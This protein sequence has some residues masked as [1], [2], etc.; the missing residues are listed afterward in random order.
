[1]AIPSYA[2]FQP[3]DNLQLPESAEPRTVIPHLDLPQIKPKPATSLLRRLGDVGVTL[4][5]SGISVPEQFIG[6]ADIP[7]SGRVG[8]F[9]EEQLNFKPKEVKA[10]LDTMY[11]PA[12]QEANQA[13]HNTEG[14]IPSLKSYAEYPSVAAHDILGQILPMASSSVIGKAA[15]IVNPKLSQLQKGVL[16]EVG[17]I[18]GQNVE[19]TRQETPGGI[20]DPVKQTLPLVG[21]AVLSGGIAGASGRLARKM[22]WTDVQNIIGGGRTIPGTGSALRN[23][24]GAMLSEGLLQEAPQSWQEQV[25]QNYALDKPLLE[26]TGSAAAQGAVAGAGLGG[27]A[28]MLDPATYKKQPPPP[29]VETLPVERPITGPITQAAAAGGVNNGSRTNETVASNEAAERST[30]SQGDGQPERGNIVA[31]TVSGSGVRGGRSGVLPVETSLGNNRVNNPD[32]AAKRNKLINDRITEL[33]SVLQDPEIDDNLRNVTERALNQYAA[34]LP[35][36]NEP[37]EDIRAQPEEQRTGTLAPG[38]NPVNM[39][40]EEGNVTNETE[41]PIWTPQEPP[42]ATTVPTLENVAQEKPASE[43]TQ[44]QPKEK[45]DLTKINPNQATTRLNDDGSYSVVHAKT[46]DDLI[47]GQTFEDK[48]IARTVFEIKRKNQLGEKTELTTGEYHPSIKPMAEELR[49]GSQQDRTPDGKR[50]QSPNPK[51]FQNGEIGVKASVTEIKDA[52]AAYSENK[53]VTPKQ[54]RILQ[55]LSDIAVRN[56]TGTDEAPNTKNQIERTVNPEIL[57]MPKDLWTQKALKDWADKNPDA[58]ALARQTAGWQIRENYDSD[59]ETAKAEESLLNSYT[60]NEIVNKPKVEAKREDVNVDSVVDDFMGA[61]QTNDVFGMTNPL[62]NINKKPETAV[63]VQETIAQPPVAAPVNET[64]VQPPIAAPVQETTAQ[65]PAAAPVQE[66]TAQ[67]PAAAPVQETLTL[68]QKINNAQQRAASNGISKNMRDA[69]IYK[70]DIDSDIT[71]KGKHN[72]LLVN[73]DPETGHI[74]IREDYQGL[75]MSTEQD[76]MQVAN[77]TYQRMHG[78][79]KKLN[80]VD[81]FDD[82]S[83]VWYRYSVDDAKKKLTAVQPPVAPAAPAVNLPVSETPAVNLPVNETPAVNLPVNETPAANTYASPSEAFR[84]LSSKTEA[85]HLIPSVYEVKGNSIVPREGVTI[86]DVTK[87]TLKPKSARVNQRT[88]NVELVDTTT[89]GKPIFPGANFKSTTEARKFFKDTQAEQLRMNASVTPLTE[90]KR[91]DKKSPIVWKGETWT[92]VVNNVVDPKNLDVRL[93]KEPIYEV[94]KITGEPIGYSYKLT[95][96]RRSTK[97]PDF[98][99]QRIESLNRQSAIKQPIAKSDQSESTTG[100]NYSKEDLKPGGLKD[101]NDVYLS[102]YFDYD[103]QQG[104]RSF[105]GEHGAELA[106]VE[107]NAFKQ[108]TGKD[109]AIKQEGYADWNGLQ[110]PVYRAVLDAPTTEATTMTKSNQLDFESSGKGLHYVTGQKA[111][112]E[113]EK[114][115]LPSYYTDAKHKNA[116]DWFKGY[117]AESKPAFDI[118]TLVEQY[119]ASGRIATHHPGKKTI[120][121]D[122][123][124][125]MPVKEAVIKMREVLAKPNDVKFSKSEETEQY[126]GEHRPPNSEEGA[127]AHNVSSNGI[128]PEDFYGQ[129]GL[130]YYSTGQDTADRESYYALQSVKNKPNATVT[131]YRTVPKILTNSDKLDKLNGDMAAYIKRGTLPKDAHIKD[132]SKWYDWAYGERERLRNLPEEAS[133]KTGINNGDWV[134]LSKTYAKEHGDSNLNGDYKIIS[135]K[136][137]AS[138]LF[139]NGDSLNEFGYWTDDTKFSKSTTAATPHTKQTL[140][141]A[142]DQEFSKSWVDSLLATGKVEFIGANDISRIAKYSN[143]GKAQAFFNP[144]NGVTYFIPENID[145]TDNVRGLMLHELGVHALQLNRDSKEFQSI[146]N[147]LNKLRETDKDVQAAFARVP[148]NT[149][150]AFVNEEVAAYLVQYHPKL[151]ITQRIIAFIRSAIRK[152]FGDKFAFSLNTKDLVYMAQTALRSAP[153]TLN[154]QTTSGNETILKSAKAQGYKGTDAGEAEEW[155]RAKAKGLDMS[156]A[157]RMERA[158]AMGFDVDRTYYHGTNQ[159]IKEF[160]LDKQGASTF[161]N[162]WFGSGISVTKITNDAYA[163]A[164]NAADRIGGNPVIYPLH[165]KKGNTFNINDSWEMNSKSELAEKLLKLTGWNE[166]ESEFLAQFHDVSGTQIEKQIKTINKKLEYFDHKYKFAPPE[167][168]NNQADEKKYRSLVKQRK[169]LIE[170]GKT[171]VRTDVLKNTTLSFSDFLGDGGIGGNRVKEILS[172]NGYDSVSVK[173]QKA[174]GNYVMDAEVTLFNPNQIRSINAAFDPDFKDSGNLLASNTTARFYSALRKG[175]MGAPDKAFTGNAQQTKLWL[176]GNMSKMGIKADEVYWTGLNDYLDSAGKGKV[177]KQDVL[178]YLNDNA[179]RVEDVVLDDDAKYADSNYTIPGGTNY[180]ELVVT[181]PT[182]EKFDESDTTHFGDAGKGKQIAWMRFDTRGDGLLI[183]EIQ[184]LRLQAGRKDGFGKGVPPAP[185]VTNAQN[186]PSDAYI[187]LLLKKAI[188]QAIDDGKTSVAWSTGAQQADLYDLSKSISKVE[189]RGGDYQELMYVDNNDDTHVIPNVPED[190]IADYI[191]KDAAK[192]LLESKPNENTGLRELSGSDLKIDSPWTH[193]MYGNENGLN[194]EGKPAL[195]TQAAREIVKKMGG[196]VDSVN[197]RP[198]IIITPEMKA[199]ILGEGMPLFGIK[200]KTLM[201]D[202]KERSTLNSNGKPIAMTE[203]EVRNFYR[204]FGD[205]KVVDEQGRP[206]VVYHGTKSDIENGVFKKGVQPW[207]DGVFFTSS[208]SIAGGV[209]AGGSDTFNREGFLDALNKLPEEYF[210]RFIARMDSQFR[211]VSFIEY[212]YNLDEDREYTDAE[213]R[214]AYADRINDMY[215]PEEGPGQ[216]T[217]RIA[218]ELGVNP[219][220]PTTGANVIATYVALKNPLEINAKGDAFNHVQQAEWL[221]KA[222]ADGRDGVVIL[223]YEDGG[224]GAFEYYTSAGRHNVYVAFS[225]SQIKSAIGNNG[226]F[227]TSNNDVRF[228]IMQDREIVTGDTNRQRTQEQL[229]AFKKTGRTVTEKSLKSQL[230]DMR[231]TFAK[232]WVQGVFDQFAPI[233]E[234]SE[235]GYMLSRL[236]KGSSGAFETFMRY[237]KLSIN[238][239]GSYN[240]DTTGGVIKNVFAPIGKET[241]DFLWWVSANRAEKLLAEDRENLFDQPKIDALKTLSD[242]TLDF[243]YKLANGQTTRNRTDAY[244][245]TLI[246]FNEFNKNALDIAEQSGLIDGAGRQFWENEFYVPFYRSMDD[247]AGVRGGDV[248]NGLIRQ[249]AIKRLKGGSDKL[250]SDLLENTLMNWSHLIDASA[251]NR[252]AKATLEAAVNHGVAKQVASNMGEYVASNG[253]LLPPGTKKTVWYKDNGAKKEFVVDDPYVLA[254]I[255]SLEYAGIKGGAMSVLGAF[256]SMLTMGVTA[257]PFFKVRNLIRDSIQSIATGSGMSYNIGKNLKEGWQLTDKTNP[258]YV[259]AL[260]AGGLIRFG[261]MLEGSES[262]RTQ[263]L[264]KLGN[265]EAS[266]LD[267]ESKIR[268]FYDATLE[269]ALA[270]YNELGNRGEEI[271]RM[272]LYHQLRQ[273]GVSEGQAA[274]M[275]RDL[276]D[277]SL[278]GTFSSIRILTKIVPFMNA[279][280]QG[281]YKLG[282]ATNEDKA[283]MATVVGAVTLASLALLTQYHDDDDW[284][285]REDW[286]R[287]NY[288]WFKFGDTAYRI[289]KPFEIG[290]LATLAE[291]TAE[292]MFDDEMTGQR[293]KER[294]AKV[295]GD[296]LAMNPIPQMIKPIIDLYANNDSFTGRPIETMGMER[297]EPQY[298]YRGDTTLVARELSKASNGTLS[299][300]QIDHLTRAYFSWLGAFVM[301]GVDMAMRGVS[302]EPSRPASDLTKVLTGNMASSLKGARSRYVSQMY[303]QAK[304][305]EQAYGTYNNL[306]KQGKIAEAREFRSENKE[307]ILKYKSVEHV[308]QAVTKL[309]D[310]IRSV[311]RSNQSPDAKRRRIEQLRNQ[312]D[313]LSRKLN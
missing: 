211:R 64:P 225:P 210:T 113:G 9:A 75:P 263:Q 110:K 106:R 231:K 56:E 143:N 161:N 12:Q 162:G 144:K 107:A 188:S 45:P 249:E 115:E 159:D 40:P 243:D 286:D 223:D 253:T 96:G 301:G 7:T 60:N 183:N 123:G 37:T 270:A 302:D 227:S 292:L 245:D 111:A 134:T 305:L 17:A 312:Q 70:K 313:R 240:S 78:T 304:E 24:G 87:I 298:R 54:T 280:L 230:Q 15:G 290:A 232:K 34:L 265:K 306:K 194:A 90:D 79:G 146:L 228:S 48:D 149:P 62:E 233:K 239:D 151:S 293:F 117:D 27:A 173:R 108:A 219:N 8:K 274:L 112:L 63:P 71:G 212:D 222:R 119:N 196:E 2:D 82:G 199:K 224:Y 49:A 59:L 262:A 132:G 288:W 145:T 43:I 287:D 72:R 131:V 309:N 178:D 185:F 6:L 190:K 41:E 122:G 279:R 177:S 289:P 147:D 55:G 166:T 95:D 100:V 85:P 291:R 152:V 69:N 124:R 130:S 97:I 236:S 25:A 58:D 214:I 23:I 294:V 268:A 242:G 18:A 252:A 127:P 208:S 175:I 104:K 235:N 89:D 13:V 30:I 51:W 91:F 241:H 191:G 39:P 139:T 169:D 5:K 276:M 14:F 261:T 57:T 93:R 140:R 257:S 66:T 311:E 155:L 172:S 92:T 295:L 36:K 105:G 142:M 80:L 273:Q 28:A 129:K 181:I 47:P 98:V 148:E 174:N 213:R 116:K 81:A 10:K 50:S 21:S 102:N 114:R 299:P 77:N 205:S 141:A 307:S 150:A 308:K 33:S 137:K 31:T 216:V 163:Y 44:E 179:V 218:G 184:S 277:F 182:V 264:I 238:A 275:A 118:P 284:K 99:G 157:A 38:S 247:E 3:D 244:K 101:Q 186:K 195:I 217:D 138:Q 226:D 68:S 76:R 200:N 22:G 234:I 156:Q 74:E 83:S 67:P 180:K 207:D 160:D 167:D 259:S 135:K 20:L 272:S 193:A 297:L 250:N 109:F 154:S 258:E 73:Q 266:I 35:P 203:E 19:Q 192:K 165:I 198:A 42:T 26:G 215:D 267:N 296:Q 103:N 52:V 237:G 202:G 221:E 254:A 168:F 65:P 282:K 206:L 300:V 209:Y 164:L 281:M 16:S 29:V 120:S 204:W 158:K 256:K 46:Q 133:V 285:K 4:W 136:V 94:G 260:A 128:Y 310:I 32:I 229:D 61:G 125:S 278:Q 126:G 255:S 271:N 86:P 84:V 283:R 248:K 153:S 197:G 121:L 88:G 176:A 269:P 220:S 187:S 189:Y 11:S 171:I 303:E 53:P 251:K 246:K 1:M 201:I 170:I